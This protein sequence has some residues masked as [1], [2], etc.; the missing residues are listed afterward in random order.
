MH[1]NQFKVKYG[2]YMVWVDF[3]FLYYF[4][5]VFPP[6]HLL[7]LAFANFTF[8]L[9][10]LQESLC[11]SRVDTV[12]VCSNEW[13]KTKPCPQ[14]DGWASY[15]CE[16]SRSFFVFFVLF[17]LLSYSRKQNH[18]K[19]FGERHVTVWLYNMIQLRSS[20]VEYFC[21]SCLCMSKVSN[22][23]NADTRKSR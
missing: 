22:N 8:K 4:L 16:C 20:R 7:S 11:A 13:R 18:N 1:E 3:V 21:S 9:V 5:T 17:K 19:Y 23:C 10:H 15:E 12:T 6:H 14:I 2:R